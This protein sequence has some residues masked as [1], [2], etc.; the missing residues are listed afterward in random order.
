MGWR[1]VT[2]EIFHFALLNTFGKDGVG[3]LPADFERE[4]MRD[5]DGGNELREEMGWA[6]E[7]G[8]P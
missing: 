5:A 1:G 2:V 3:F 6:W 7:V 4:K 8:A